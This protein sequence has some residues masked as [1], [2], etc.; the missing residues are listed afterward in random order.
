MD[1]QFVCVY[2]ILTEVMFVTELSSNA[3]ISV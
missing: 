2:N 3:E 1:K